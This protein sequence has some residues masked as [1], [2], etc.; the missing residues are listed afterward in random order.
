MSSAKSMS[1]NT[2]VKAHVIPF[3][4]VF[5]V[6]FISQSMQRVKRNGDK[7]HSQSNLR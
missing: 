4:S 6:S 5:V 1:Y 7:I 2:L 3:L